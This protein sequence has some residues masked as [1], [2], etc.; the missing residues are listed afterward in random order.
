MKKFLIILLVVLMSALE[1]NTRSLSLIYADDDE[2]ACVFDGNQDS[3]MACLK[4]Q[5]NSLSNQ[6]KEAQIDME[7]FTEIMNEAKSNLDSLQAD[8]NELEPQI[9]ELETRIEELEISIAENEEKVEELRQRILARMAEAQTSMH[10]NPWLDFILGSNGF[11]DMLRRTYGVEAITQKEEKDRKELLQIIEQ[12]NAD[13]AECDEK[14]AELDEKMRKLQAAKVEQQ[15]IQQEYKAKVTELENYI[16]ELS[17]QLDTIKK[18]LSVSYSLNL[19]EYSSGFI[20]P[21]SGANIGQG[22]PYYSDGTKH[23]GIDYNGVS[24]GTPILAPADGVVIS[25]VNGCTRDRGNNYGNS[26]PYGTSEQGNGSAYLGNQARY[27]T[28]VNGYVY[29]FLFCHMLAGSVT[30]TGNIYVGDTIGQVG[31]SGNSTGAH[32]H[33]EMFYLGKGEIEDLDYYIDKYGGYNGFGTV[34]TI[35]SFCKYKGGAPCRLDPRNYLGV[36]EAELEW[37]FY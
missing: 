1:F 13:K 15:L 3:Y 10:F 21:I 16:E 22:V 37:D 23:L 36:K 27:I 14:K 17:A 34:Y 25:T 9:E 26:C 20:N 19:L 29:G 30:S 8:I 4:D 2:D 11:A 24:Y 31:S 7:N 32:C 35:S 12:L 18:A 5:R 28:S 6:I 33:I